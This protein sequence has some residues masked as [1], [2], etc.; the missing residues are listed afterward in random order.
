MSV[1]A[2]AA[3]SGD[4]VTDVIHASIAHLDGADD[5]TGLDT[6]TDTDTDDTTAEPVAAVDTNDPTGETAVVAEG[7]PAAPVKKTPKYIP[8]NR[9][10]AQVK[11]KQKLQADIKAL[12]EKYQWAEI[13]PDA[14]AK[15]QAMG[16]VDDDPERFIEALF[17]D[18]RYS[19]R[20]TRREKEQVAAAVAEATQAVTPPAAEAAPTFPEPDVML[21]DGTATYSPQALQ[22][23]T[24]AVAEHHVRQERTQGE[25]RY[26]ALEK[27]FDD[28]LSP[29]E[30][31]RSDKVLVDKA[32]TS[33]QREYDAIAAA[34]G[35][36][37]VKAN[38]T[39]LREW[40]RRNKT[41]DLYRAAN[42]L[43]PAKLR[44]AHEAERKTLLGKADGARATV[45][46]ETNTRAAAPAARVAVAKHVPESKGPRD[47]E[48][49]IMDSLRAKGL[50]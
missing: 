41:T 28:R 45:I 6:S 21:S 44:E 33:K 10:D 16:I 9:F 42:A 26:K 46:S 22:K 4:A 30:R 14:Q 43:L 5:D 34:W 12:Q 48:A 8:W 15:Y 31:E 29:F 2:G 11:E 20:L 23:Y 37:L 13:D 39:E 40:C 25:A 38:K 3:G 35:E 27:K 24:Q 1:E 18:E 50:V 36:E 49:I 7:E 17:T 32:I 19:S 47:T